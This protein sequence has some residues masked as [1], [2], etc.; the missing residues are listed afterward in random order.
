MSS[1]NKPACA[2]CGATGYW[3]GFSP[4]YGEVRCINHL[5]TEETPMALD[6]DAR[7]R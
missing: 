3:V 2:V 1:R 5:H 6:D 7:M 4:A